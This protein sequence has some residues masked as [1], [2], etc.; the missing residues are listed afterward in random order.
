M[1][2]FDKPKRVNQ[3]SKWTIYRI[4]ISTLLTFISERIAN[5]AI[6]CISNSVNLQA[7][8]LFL[9]HLF[10]LALFLSFRL[11]FTFTRAPFRQYL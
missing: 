8:R 1:H 9:S 2:V 4:Y 11:S 6:A 7:I 5:I 3:W 10:S